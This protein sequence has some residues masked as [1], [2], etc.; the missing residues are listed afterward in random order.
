PGRPRPPAP[1]PRRNPGPPC[2]SCAWYMLLLHASLRPTMPATIRPIETI[3]MAD[4]EPPTP[5]MPTTNAP[6]PVQ[7]AY[8]VGMPRCAHRSNA[9]LAVPAELQPDRP[10]VLA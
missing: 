6:P 5:G 1:R 9:P 4:A 2:P 3:R 8:P 10:A 7:I